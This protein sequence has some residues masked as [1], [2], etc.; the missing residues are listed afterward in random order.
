MD[1][2]ELFNDT[3]NF[4]SKYLYM[5]RHRHCHRHRHHHL[6]VI[7]NPTLLFQSIYRNIAIETFPNLKIWRSRRR[8]RR[9]REEV[10]IVEN[11]KVR[12]TVINNFQKDK[13]VP[14]GTEVSCVGK[15]YANILFLLLLI[16]RNCTSYVY[17]INERKVYVP[18]FEQ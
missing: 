9:R 11:Q 10:Y 18:N 2:E 8:R 6:F 1:G 12:T 15:K 4:F 13:Y 7:T 14:Y 3:R 16:V 5:Y 17:K